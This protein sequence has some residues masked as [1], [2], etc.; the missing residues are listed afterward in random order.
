MS[1]TIRNTRWKRDGMGLH[2]SCMGNN[3]TEYHKYNIGPGGLNC[4]CCTK[5]PPD[6]MKVKQR[7][8]VRRNEKMKLNK[9]FDMV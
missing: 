5:L 8:Y 1:R 9:D 7:R 4:P 2:K 6:E 3:R